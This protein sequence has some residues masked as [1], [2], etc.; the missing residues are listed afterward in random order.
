V[1]LNYLH[2][3]LRLQLRGSSGITPRFPTPCW[4]TVGG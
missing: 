2:V 4:L 3:S 1:A